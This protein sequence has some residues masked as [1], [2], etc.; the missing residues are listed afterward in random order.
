MEWWLLVSLLWIAFYTV[1]VL[2]LLGQ[3]REQ[4]LRQ[5]YLLDRISV[6][7]ERLNDGGGLSRG[8]TDGG[9]DGRREKTRDYRRIF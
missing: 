2:L 8:G 9:A 3:L 7:V 1:N 6:L 5:R 4:S